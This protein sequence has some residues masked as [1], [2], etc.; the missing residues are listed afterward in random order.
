[1]LP[2]RN[3][4]EIQDHREL[5]SKLWKKVYNTYTNHR[6]VR[7]VKLIWDEVN[8]VAKNISRIKRDH[9]VMI[10]GSIH[11]ELI[12]IPSVCAPRNRAWKVQRREQARTNGQIQ[13]CS[14]S[15]T[16]NSQ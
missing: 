12:T 3:E 10:K 13:N 16:I 1:M 14:W 9:F 15:L 11:L 5:K 7:V 2:S 6:K 4:F 8:F